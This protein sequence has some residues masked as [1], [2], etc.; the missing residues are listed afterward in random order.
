MKI[1]DLIMEVRIFTNNFVKISMVEDELKVIFDDTPTIQFDENGMFIILNTFQFREYEMKESFKNFFLS[2]AGIIDEIKNTSKFY[3][4]YNKPT[5]EKI[6]NTTVTP[7]TPIQESVFG[8]CSTEKTIDVFYRRS[9]IWGKLILKP[10]GEIVDYCLP[11]SND[12][13]NI[14]KSLVDKAVRK[15]DTLSYYDESGIY[16]SNESNFFLKYGFTQLPN[17]ANSYIFKN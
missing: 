7:T 11:R 2:D 4:E 12:R 6:D 10:S 8:N 13:Y 1:H 9:G 5:D 16:A 3:I 15:F 17:D 14:F